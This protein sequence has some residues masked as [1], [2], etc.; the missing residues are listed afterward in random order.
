MTLKQI[1]PGTQNLVFYCRIIRR[2]YKKLFMNVGL[3][4]CLHEHTNF[5]LLHLVYLD[6]S[7]YSEINIHFGHAQKHGMNMYEY[8]SNL[9]TVPGKI[10]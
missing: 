9:S 3:I 1:L 5:L 6:C 10:I 8:H 4:V 7:K 2:R